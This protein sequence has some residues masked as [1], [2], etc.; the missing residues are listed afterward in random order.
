MASLRDIKKDIDYLV[1]EVVFDCYLAL[2]FHEDRKDRII[3]VMQDAVDLRNELFEMVNNPAEKHN[4]SL[5]KKHYRFIRMQMFER[6]DGLFNKLSS[7]VN[8]K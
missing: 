7:V 5:V 2:Y 6:I 4:P 8:E 3:P 1:N